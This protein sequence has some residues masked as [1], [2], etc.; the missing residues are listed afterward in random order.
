MR[1]TAV[2]NSTRLTRRGVTPVPPQSLGHPQ[3]GHVVPILKPLLGILPERLEF[4]PKGSHA[5]VL[6]GDAHDVIVLEERTSRVDKLGTGGDKGSDDLERGGNPAQR[7]I[8]ALGRIL[9]AGRYAGVTF[10]RSSRQRGAN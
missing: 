10:G 9:N 5:V 8:V 3:R 2:T 4:T 7:P 1:N 6:A